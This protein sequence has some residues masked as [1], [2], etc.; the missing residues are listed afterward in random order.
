VPARRAG[1]APG[2]AACAC[3]AASLPGLG[4]GPSRCRADLVWHVL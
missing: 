1:Y 4:C 3:G 2:R